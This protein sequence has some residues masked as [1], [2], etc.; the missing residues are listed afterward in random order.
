MEPEPGRSRR[1]ERGE[2]RKKHVGKRTTPEVEPKPNGEFI[3]K[4]PARFPDERRSELLEKAI[5]YIT[6][7]PY[8]EAFP[9]RLYAVDRDGTIYT[10][11]T[12]NPGDSYHGY[13]YTGRMGKHLIA[14]LREMARSEGC[15]VAFNAW[16]KTYIKVGGPPDL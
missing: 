2:N 12:S 8:S 3:G 14:A 9:K 5:P 4:C 6:G 16:I 10:A 13:P 11:Q 1:Y 15:E 7:S